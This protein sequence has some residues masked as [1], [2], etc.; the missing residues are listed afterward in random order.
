[1]SEVDEAL[2]AHP[3]DVCAQN[4]PVIERLQ[5][6]LRGAITQAVPET[7]NGYVLLDFPN[8]SNVG[9]SAI[10][11]GELLLMREHF[12]SGPLLVAEADRSVLERLERLPDSVPLLMHG[13]GNFGDLYPRYQQFREI[14]LERFRSRKVVL[15]PQS[16]H[17]DDEANAEPIARSIAAHGDVTLMVRDRESEAF[18][19]RRFDCRVMLVPDMAFMIGPI[20]PPAAWEVDLFALLRQDKERVLPEAVGLAGLPCSHASADWP[21]E[22]RMRGVIGRVPRTLRASL[23]AAWQGVRPETPAAFERLA[24]WRVARGLRLLSRGRMVLTDRLHAHILS[25]LLGKPHVVLDNTYGKIARFTA[26][27]TEGGAFVRAGTLPA[28]LEMV[29]SAHREK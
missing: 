17:F 16:I 27:W 20:A 11:L 8:H 28:A 22:G 25:L 7:A 15:L 13:G 23:P 18:A 9:D 1:M 14:V 24:H 26:S 2:R 4:R 6:A 10:Y 19:R 21:G 29:R 3:A 5:A 12:G